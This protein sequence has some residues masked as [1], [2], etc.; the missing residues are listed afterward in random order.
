MNI[1]IYFMDS[2]AADQ[3]IYFEKYFLSYYSTI[4]IT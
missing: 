4:Q 2:T 3:V 1:N